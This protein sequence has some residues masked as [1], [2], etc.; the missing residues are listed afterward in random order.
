MARQHLCPSARCEEGAILVGV[1]LGDGRVA[2][3]AEEARIDAEF[4]AI[5]RE[6]RQ[7]ES[8]FRFAGRCVQGAC[9]QWTG[10]RCGVIDRVLDEGLAAAAS[11]PATLPQCSIRAQCRWFDQ[12]GAD[13]CAA[14]PVVITSPSD[15]E[16]LAAGV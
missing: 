10:S 6:G 9:R 4:V 1:V 13:A 2:Y 5:A 15:R 14:C 7:P 16:P 11:M 3:A 8:R 12:A